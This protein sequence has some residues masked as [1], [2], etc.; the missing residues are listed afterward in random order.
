MLHLRQYPF[1]PSYLVV[2]FLHPVAVNTR[3]ITVCFVIRPVLLRIISGC[4]GHFRRGL[5][6]TTLP[7]VRGTFRM[8]AC[9]PS[10]LPR[11][12]LGISVTDSCRRPSLLRS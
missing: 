7:T 10:C 8:Y 6:R 1:S 9:C 11:L 4:L 3:S 5:T 12:F 2:V